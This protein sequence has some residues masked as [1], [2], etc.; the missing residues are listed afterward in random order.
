MKNNENFKGGDCFFPKMKNRKII[1]DSAKS[2]KMEI[3]L[4]PDFSA[5]LLFPDF[6]VWVLE[7]PLECASSGAQQHFKKVCTTFNYK[8]QFNH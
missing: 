6:L 8:I 3:L 1:L 5:T 2:R 7:L 4:F